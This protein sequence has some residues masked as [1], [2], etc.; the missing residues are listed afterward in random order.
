MQKVGFTGGA[1]MN[2]HYS[3][4]YHHHPGQAAIMGAAAANTLMPMYPLHYFHQSH[5]MGLPAHIYS[6]TPVTA[7]PIH[8]VPALISKPISI[9]PPKAG[10][11]L[12]LV[13]RPKYGHFNTICMF[14]E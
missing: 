9:T 14:G 7:G 6:P 13:V 11:L 12:L 3:Q 2:G 4:V 10:T 1:Y 5:T 8:T